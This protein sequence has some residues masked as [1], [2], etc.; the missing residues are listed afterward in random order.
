MQPDPIRQAY[1]DYVRKVGLRDDPKYCSFV[2]FAAGAKWAA[3]EAVKLCDQ[4]A[5]LF[6]GEA[7]FGERA[8]TR[9]CA[10]AIRKHFG[11]EGDSP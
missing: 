2:D 7:G 11:V 3:R 5:E 6:R 10:Y 1:D 8:G 4:R 9:G